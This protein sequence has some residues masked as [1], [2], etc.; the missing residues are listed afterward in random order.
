MDDAQASALPSP[1]SCRR[2]DSNW[3]RASTC[4]RTWGTRG[5]DLGVSR[6]G[7]SPGADLG[8]SSEYSIGALHRE[9]VEDWSGAG[10]RANSR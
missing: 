6:V 2:R 5:A 9:Q 1:Y 7:A 4:R 3:G 10:F 8:C